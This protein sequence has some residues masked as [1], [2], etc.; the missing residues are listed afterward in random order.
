MKS[1]DVSLCSG[2]ASSRKKSP[3]RQAT[4]WGKDKTRT[5]RAGAHRGPIGLEHTEQRPADVIASSLAASGH[6]HVGLVLPC[7]LKVRERTPQ[8]R[9]HGTHYDLV[10]IPP[11]QPSYP[12]PTAVPTP[13]ALQTWELVLLI[14]VALLMSSLCKFR[15]LNARCSDVCMSSLPTRV[16]SVAFT[17]PWWATSRE[18]FEALIAAEGYAPY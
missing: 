18:R 14:I 11:L 5:D 16:M 1:S 9:S 2:M 6:L 10:R 12:S 4:A 13:I 15:V 17:P 7:C 3:H 8:T